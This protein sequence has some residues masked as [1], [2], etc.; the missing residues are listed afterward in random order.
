MK[1]LK[2]ITQ[3]KKREIKPPKKNFFLF[4]VLLIIGLIVGYIGLGINGFLGLIVILGA[5][6]FIIASIMQ[7]IGTSECVCPNC[8]TNGYI[9]KY[10]KDYKCKACGTKSVVIVEDE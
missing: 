9:F 5:N 10:A 8:E 3:D 6:T 7:I 2:S 4:A 1:V